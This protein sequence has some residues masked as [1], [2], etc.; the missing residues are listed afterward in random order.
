MSPRASIRSISAGGWPATLTGRLGTSSAKRSRKNPRA[1]AERGK[2]RQV[3]VLRLERAA[4]TE[5]EDL[6][7]AAR[8]V[9]G[10]V[11]GEPGRE[12]Q[13]GE[14]AK[15][16]GGA[17]RRGPDQARGAPAAP[18][19]TTRASS[20]QPKRRLGLVDD[21][22]RR[23]RRAE[24]ADRLPDRGAGDDGRR[25]RRGR[26]GGGAI[27]RWS[28]A[29]CHPD[30]R[31]PAAAS[32]P[33][34]PRSSSSLSSR[35]SGRLRVGEHRRAPARRRAARLAAGERPPGRP[36]ERR[37]APARPG[38]GRRG[39]HR[40]RRRGTA[41]D[42]RRPGAA[43]R[44]PRDRAAPPAGA[45]DAGVG[46]TRA[47]SDG[48]W[49][50]VLDTRGDALLVYRV[51]PALEL[52]R[53]VY[54][55][56]GPVALALDPVKHRLWVTLAETNEVVELPAHGRPDRAAPLPDR[57]PARPG[58]R[59]RRSAGVVYV[60]GTEALQRVHARPALISAPARS[61][62]GGRR[63]RG[64]SPSPM[65]PDGGDLEDRG[66]AAARRRRDGDDEPEDDGDDEDDRIASG[67]SR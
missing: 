22:E 14:Q 65:H 67:R 12:G 59:R 35:R 2:P 9:A 48:R 49:L 29:R 47:L 38:P 39:P 62:S 8:A 30:K 56:G 25:A 37:P 31:C 5:H 7:P 17:D 13:Q 40:R 50:W 20:A 57:P 45:P 51:R 4:G 32:P 6:A 15:P 63:S 53:R 27:A 44:A 52:A 64:P 24:A 19:H 10:G 18:A 21:H 43:G 11:Q 58:G 36:P 23:G 41:G 46:P 42:R 28:G 60:R 66:A 26:R 1:V 61:A 34:R 3:L 16:P 54:L 33:D 55:P